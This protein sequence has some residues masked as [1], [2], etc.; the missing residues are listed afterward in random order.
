MGTVGIAP[1]ADPD[2]YSLHLYSCRTE[3]HCLELEGV[4]KELLVVCGVVPGKKVEGVIR[5][6]MENTK[7][8]NH[9][10]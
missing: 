8:N 5:L 4:A 2:G 9:K 7:Y 10:Q 1:L 6:I 3:Q